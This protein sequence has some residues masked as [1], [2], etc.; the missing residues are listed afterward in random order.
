[1][2]PGGMMGGA[3]MGGAA[4]GMPGGGQDPLAA[5][6]QAAQIVPQVLA[7]QQAEYYKQFLKQIGKILREF[8]RMRTIGPHTQIDVNRAVTQLAAAEGRID[9][10][11][12]EV[13]PP[14][15]SLMAQGMMQNRPQASMGAQAGLPVQMR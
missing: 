12:P 1:M 11:R 6:T 3:D 9:K 14:V 7:Q 15:D 13:A 10:E 2:P 8:A 4:G 5:L